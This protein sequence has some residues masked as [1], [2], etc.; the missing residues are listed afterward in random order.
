MT[1]TTCPR[2]P[3]PWS[4]ED[5]GGL[6][7]F[8]DLDAFLAGVFQQHL[9]ELAADD[10]PGDGRFMLQMLVEIERRGDPAVLAGELHGILPRE[11]RLLKLLDHADPLEREVTERQQ[12]FADV[13]AGEFFLFQQQHFVPMHGQDGRSGRAGRPA[14]HDDHVI[15]AFHSQQKHL[16]S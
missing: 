12:R 7:L 11:V 5:A 15:F 6:G 4:A 14:A 2:A 16:T 8:A 10:L 9:V 3:V 13:I 1:P